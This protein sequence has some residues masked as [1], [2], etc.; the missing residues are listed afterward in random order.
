[1]G[2]LVEEYDRQRDRL[3]GNYP[4]ALSPLHLVST[5]L[6]LD[7]LAGPAQRRVGSTEA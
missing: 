4:Q 2:L 3:A 6:C 1:V 5:A 7:R